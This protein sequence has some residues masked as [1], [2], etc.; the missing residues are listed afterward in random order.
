VDELKKGYREGE[1]GVKKAGRKADGEDLGDKVANLGDDIRK[2]LGNAGDDIRSAGDDA[3]DD[4]RD[5][6]LR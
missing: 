6:D 2:N 3:R 4:V 5:D 1:T